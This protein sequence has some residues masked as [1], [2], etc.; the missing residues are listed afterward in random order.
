MKNLILAAALFFLFNT[1]AFASNEAKIF[2]IKGKPKI[3]KDGKADWKN[4]K[5]DMQIA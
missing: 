2:H 1:Q 3:V 4:C 5:V